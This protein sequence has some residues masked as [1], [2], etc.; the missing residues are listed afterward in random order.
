MFALNVFIGN[1]MEK[2]KFSYQSVIEALSKKKGGEGIVVV[3]SFIFRDKTLGILEALVKY[4]KEE[5][6]LRYHKIAVLLNRDDRPIWMTYSK[7]V[8]KKK[9]RFV[10]KEPNRWIP[11]SIFRNRALG[12]LESISLYLKDE[13]NLSLSETAELLD[14]SN[15]TI[16]ACYHKGKQKKDEKNVEAGNGE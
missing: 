16:W 4:L 11:I 8:K 15:S 5:L 7:A 12:P 6:D 14:R 10:V 13:L 2:H 9:Q 3:P 1:I